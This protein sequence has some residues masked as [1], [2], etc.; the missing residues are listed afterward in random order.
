[1]PASNEPEIRP[2]RLEDCDDACRLMDALDDWHRD[3]LPWLF[4]ASNDQPR[5]EASFADLLE[6]QD[7]A[8]FV[9][10]AGGIVGVAVGQLRAA[11]DLP[12]FIQQRW[13]V[14]DALVVDPAWR[15][16]GIGKRLAHAV[17]AWAI[18][19]GAPWVEV[20]VYQVNDE[21]RRFYEALGYLPV[22]MKLRRPRP[23]AS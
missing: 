18:G 2:A 13:G 17:E 10:D 12:V 5:P 14:L 4:Q 3:R 6:R 1:M 8:V 23:D 9:A 22:S 15:R 11:P 19:S 21:A 16:R 7:L 20:N